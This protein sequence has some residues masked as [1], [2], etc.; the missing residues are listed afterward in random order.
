MMILESIFMMAI[1]ILEIPTGII[2]DKFGRKISMILGFIVNLIAI[3][4]Y[5]FTRNFWW[6]VLGEIIWAL[7][8]ALASGANEALLYDTLLILGEEKHSQQYF[9]R[10]KSFMLGGIMVGSIIGSILVTKYFEI[11]FTMLFSIIPIMIAVLIS[12]LIFEPEEHMQ[13]EKDSAFQ[14]FKNG[15][16]TIKNNKNLQIIIFD[17]IVLNAIAYYSIWL[18]NIRLD[19]LGVKIIYFGFIQSGMLL[20]Q[21]FLLTFIQKIEKILQSKKRVIT[22]TGLGMGVG[23]ILFGSS[24]II[25][26]ALIGLFLAAGLGLSRPIIMQNYMQKYIE[27]EQRATTIS[28]ISMMEKL[29]IAIF[30]PIIGILAELNLSYVLIGLG[31]IAILL[32]SCSR[33]QEAHLID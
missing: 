18:W 14:I 3:L 24:N 25:L 26:L 21:I 1:L 22:F 4:I 19:A 11:R 13:K 15:L 23:F 27:T 5:S 28:T 20:T 17:M 6:Y 8:V 12:F 30:N 16:K 9:A 29:L 33:I 10:M 7:S 31:V 32:N 2:A